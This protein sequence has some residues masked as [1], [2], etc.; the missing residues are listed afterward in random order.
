M[1]KKL[2]ARKMPEDF[3]KMKEFNEK[4]KKISMKMVFGKNATTKG[5]KKEKKVPKG[6]HRMSDGSIMKDSDM[7][8]TT[9]G[10]TTKGASATKGK[11][12][13]KNIKKDKY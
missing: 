2:K 9:K 6:S 5:K 10:K 3:Y 11:K 13:K 7:K 8:K 12:K 4:D 1:P